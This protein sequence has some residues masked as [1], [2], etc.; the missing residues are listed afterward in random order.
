MT[1][2]AEA[3]SRLTGSDVDV[4]TLWTVTLISFVILLSCLCIEL[5]GLDFGLF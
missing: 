3:I 1:V 2:L 4:E 5:S